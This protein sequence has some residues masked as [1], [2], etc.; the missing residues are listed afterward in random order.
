MVMFL[1]LYLMEY[2]FL[3]RAFS[4]VANF[5]TCNLLF[6]QEL[7]KGY[8]YHK[9]KKNHFFSKFRVLIYVFF[10]RGGEGGLSP[11]DKINLLL[12][13]F[14]CCLFGGILKYSK[15]RSKCIH[16]FRLKDVSIDEMVGA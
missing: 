9:L 5:N 3:A 7:L 15:W 8:Q 12:R 13:G 14:N 16:W 11:T 10:V 2:I 6:T 1:A 4:H